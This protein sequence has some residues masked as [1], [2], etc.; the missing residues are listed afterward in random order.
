MNQIVNYCYSCGGP[1]R[2]GGTCAAG[3]VSLMD[4]LVMAEEEMKHATMGA[5][6]QILEQHV[7]TE[8][9]ERTFRALLR[10]RRDLVEQLTDMTEAQYESYRLGDWRVAE[11]EGHNG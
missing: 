7:E 11:S 9:K 4:I 5:V 10:L 6:L 8:V 1:V 2:A 3:H